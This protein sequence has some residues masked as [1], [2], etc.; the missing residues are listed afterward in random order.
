MGFRPYVLW[1]TMEKRNREELSEKANLYPPFPSQR[2]KSIPGLDRKPIQGKASS[3][4]PTNQLSMMLH[5]SVKM[6]G[7]FERK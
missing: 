4:E 7:K 3:F 2:G 5:V 6:A 1:C